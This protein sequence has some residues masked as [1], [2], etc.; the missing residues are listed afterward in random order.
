MQKTSNSLTEGSILTTLVRFAVPYLLANF[1][2]ALYSAVDLMIIGW[3]SNDAAISGVN[4]AT[5][6]IQTLQS[7][8]IGLAMGGTIL[9]GQYVGARRDKDAEQT[10]STILTMFIILGALFTVGI[11]I[12]CDPLLRLMQTPAEAF[13]SASAYVRVIGCGIIFSFGYNA[14][15]AILRGLG[16]STRPLLFVAVA[17]VTNMVLDYLMVGPLNMGAGGAALATIISQALSVALAILYLRRI[18][19]PFDFR[20]SS[21]RLH[22][23]KAAGLLKLGIPVCMQET[24]VSLSFLIIIAIINGIG[25]VA[26][27]AVGIAGKFENFAMLPASAFGGAIAAIA[28]Q[29]MGAGR[30]DRAVKSLWL[31]VG[32]SLVPSIVFFFWAQWMPESILGLFGAGGE[33]AVAGAAYLKS[34]SFDFILTCFGF[35]LL[36]FFNGCGCT[37]FASI[38]GIVASVVIRL[39]LAYILSRLF[40]SDLTAV[41]MAVP[42]ATLISV[43]GAL[44][45]MKMGRWKDRSAQT[46]KAQ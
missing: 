39:P 31:S 17:C 10:I 35:T 27:A 32:L 24:L 20:P 43:T 37:V 5:Q 12:F 22:R 9:I 41:G 21:F 4:T 34:F 46:L 7:L 33:T 40:P 2:Q 6:L 11:L 36:G 44:I 23:D 13:D 45:Y 38:N 29:N 26:S 42:M 19:F 16:D 30:P 18:H 1:V 8:I 14:L 25:V 3:F 15:S 28:A